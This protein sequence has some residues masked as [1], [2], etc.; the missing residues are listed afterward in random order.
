M[1]DEITVS[2]DVQ[3][4]NG[5]VRTRRGQGR[6]QQI[7]QTTA[8]FVCGKVATSTSEGS[9]SISGMTKPGIMHIRNLSDTASENILIGTSTGQYDQQYNPGEEFAFRL[10]DAAT[11]IYHKSD[12]GTPEFEY[13]ILED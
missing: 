10:N 5:N 6:N 11:T 7:D 8:D 9:F 2:I 13:L 1:A 4:I 12:L 3:L